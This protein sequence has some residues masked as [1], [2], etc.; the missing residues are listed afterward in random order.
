MKKDEYQEFLKSKQ[1][2]FIESGFEIDESELTLFKKTS[3][4]TQKEN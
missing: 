1:K 2:T 3:C 4:T